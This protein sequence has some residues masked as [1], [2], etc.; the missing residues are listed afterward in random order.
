[1][2]EKISIRNRKSEYEKIQK[3]SMVCFAIEPETKRAVTDIKY[4]Y[5]QEG[6]DV[7]MYQRNK[8][9]YTEPT[10]FKKGTGNNITEDPPRTE[11]NISDNKIT[12][13]D[14]GKNS[15]AQDEKCYTCN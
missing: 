11:Q 2:N 7:E 3:E 14:E 12:Q 10:T 8:Q 9:I 4:N 13:S 5:L 1:M 6:W 15:L